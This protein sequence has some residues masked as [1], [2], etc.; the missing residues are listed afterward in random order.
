M[1]RETSSFSQKYMHGKC[2]CLISATC[3]QWNKE[4][5][6]WGGGNLPRGCIGAPYSPWV[7]MSQKGREYIWIL[8]NTF[9]SALSYL[10]WGG[11]KGTSMIYRGSLLWCLVQ[12]Q[13]LHVLNWVEWGNKGTSGV[14]ICRRQNESI[15]HP[16]EWPLQ[17]VSLYN[18]YFQLVELFQAVPHLWEKNDQKNFF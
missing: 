1:C 9:S 16:H 15:W 11:T 17:P 14:A 13:Y 5:L 18:M 3:F 7:W 6:L 10:F 2:L 12:H 4:N 8:I